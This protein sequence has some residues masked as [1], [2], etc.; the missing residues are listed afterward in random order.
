MFLCV[1]NA[2][3]IL[4]HILL[5]ILLIVYLLRCVITQ[6]LLVIGSLPQSCPLIE[7]A[8]GSFSLS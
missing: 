7:V 3:F 8:L 5:S 2:H 1:Q 6:S 4:L